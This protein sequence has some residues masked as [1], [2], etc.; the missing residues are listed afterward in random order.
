MI[1]KIL[2]GSMIIFFSILMI[3]FVA[4][5]FVENWSYPNIFPSEISFRMWDTAL[6]KKRIIYSWI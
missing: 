3:K 6:S 1:K 2:E 4:W 5:A